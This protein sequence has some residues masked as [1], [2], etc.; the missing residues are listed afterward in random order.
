MKGAYLLNVPSI[1]AMVSCH[2][3]SKS[4]FV[5]GVL[6]IGTLSVLPIDI[7]FLPHTFRTRFTSF[8]LRMYYLRRIT[9]ALVH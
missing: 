6:V 7:I 5:S 2:L 4:M 8:I 1:S 3:I 9:K